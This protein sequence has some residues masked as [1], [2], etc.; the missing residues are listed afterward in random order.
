[1]LMDNQTPFTPPTQTP[2]PPP[3]PTPPEPPASVVVPQ[4][5]PQTVTV[6]QSKLP[7]ILL[8]LLILLLL[9]GL[10]FLGYTYKKTND[11]LGAKS[12]ELSGAYQTIA[13]YQ[14]IIDRHDVTGNF[15]A[16]ENNAKLS[17]QMCGGTPLGMFD[18]Y[19][20]DKFA[21]F[22]YLCSELTSAA[23]IRIGALKKLDDGTYE[24]TYGSSDDK[25]NAIPS[26]IYDTDADY[27]KNSYK[28]TNL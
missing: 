25:P 15:I 9:A 13:T 7:K 1:M 20:N 21:V 6:K 3:A 27:F 11:A 8:I 19:I 10:G 4:Q 24:F 2:P 5:G 28:A 18:V 16:K 22:R 23:P 12:K 26:Y 17:Q 14:G